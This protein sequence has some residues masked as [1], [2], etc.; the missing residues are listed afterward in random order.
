VGYPFLLAF[1]EGVA[2]FVSQCFKESWSILLEMD[3]YG[4]FSSIALQ[5]AA[6]KFT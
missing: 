6:T 4:W 3:G 1:S 2:D 5:L